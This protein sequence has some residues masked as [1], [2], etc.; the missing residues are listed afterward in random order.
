MAEV[1]TA[2]FAGLTTFASSAAPVVSTAL[3]VLSGAATVTSVLMGLKSANVEQASGVMAAQENAINADVS[4][5]EGR[6]AATESEAR[7]LE[8]KRDTLRKIG[9]A[10]VAFAASGLDISSRQLAN[11]EDDIE[12]ESGYQLALEEQNKRM[13]L[14]E[15]DL[16]AGQY[17]LRTEAAL[18]ASNAK[19]GAR[20]S[21][22]YLTGT[23]GLLS[24]VKRG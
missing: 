16:K 12:D 1:A 4:L 17:G 22:A 5:L 7:A 11:I 14:A 13:A 3:T 18:V 2:A 19:A 23:R 10:R 20:R 9:A 24:I 6:R 21:D 15:A 8:I